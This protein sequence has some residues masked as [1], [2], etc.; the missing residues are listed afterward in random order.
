MS[1][2]DAMTGIWS[3]WKTALVGAH[4][5]LRPLPR[6]CPRR[7]GAHRG[8][9]RLRPGSSAPACAAGPC[10]P[11]PAEARCWAAARATLRSAGRPQASQTRAWLG[12]YWCAMH[13]A[14]G[15]NGLRTGFSF[16]VFRIACGAWVAAARSSH[17]GFCI[18]EPARRCRPL[19]CLVRCTWAFGYLSRTC[20]GLR[21]AG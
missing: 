5:R 18:T 1:A 17:S 8:P 2:C 6:W 10:C 11:R 20:R 3:G 15:Q 4:H 12:M 7:R 21:E 16:L 19:S 9:W 14:S 13:I